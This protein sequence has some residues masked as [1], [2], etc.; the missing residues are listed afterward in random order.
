LSSLRYEEEGGED[1]VEK[2]TS[3]EIDALRVLDPLI[4]D[5]FRIEAILDQGSEIIEMNRDVWLKLG[6]GLDPQKIL[7]MTS[8]NSQLNTT[9]GVITD[10]K[11]TL[12]EINLPLQ[13][14]VV[15][16]SPFDLLLGR[17]FFRFT[18]CQTTDFP[19][20]MQ[21]ITITCPNTGRKV[22]IPTHKKSLKSR[23][24]FREC[25]TTGFQAARTP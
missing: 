5:T 3:S 7:N 2:L 23:N 16:G 13:I 19:D 1:R 21:E 24:L 15:K 18:S 6:V 12:K 9:S 22:T 4:N 25:R 20:G 11:L 10:L 8:A 14:H 17:P